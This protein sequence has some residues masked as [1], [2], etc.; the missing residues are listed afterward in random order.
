V[1]ERDEG[2]GNGRGVQQQHRLAEAKRLADD[3]CQDRQVHGI[4][5]ESIESADD[6]AVGWRDGRGGANALD[7]ES[8]ECMNQYQGSRYE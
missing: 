6:Q 4:T 1:N 8:R 3:D 5:Y 7:D 2:D